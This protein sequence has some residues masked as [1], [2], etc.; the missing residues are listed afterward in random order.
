[1]WRISGRAAGKEWNGSEKQNGHIAAGV[2][3][4]VI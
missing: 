4:T 3:I 2:I 1:M